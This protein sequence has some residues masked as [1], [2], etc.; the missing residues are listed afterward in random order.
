MAVGTVKVFDRDK[1]FGFIARKAGSDI[2]VH[3]SG[4]AEPDCE[5]LEPGDRVRFD[6]VQGR[7]GP[8]AD[9]VIL[10]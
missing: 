7:K 3:V 1:G 4:I 10:L 8:V 5:W 2:F 6:I 9:Q